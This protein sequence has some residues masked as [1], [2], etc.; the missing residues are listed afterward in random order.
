M[1]RRRH[2]NDDLATISMM[3]HRNDLVW[4]QLFQGGLLESNSVT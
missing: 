3:R 4:V 1:V 2:I